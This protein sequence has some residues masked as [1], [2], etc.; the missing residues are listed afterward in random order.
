[1]K[2]LKL[3]E[4]QKFS[5]VR[6]EFIAKIFMK[7]IDKQKVMC[8]NKD[9]ER[10]VFKL[11]EYKQKEIRNLVKQGMAI[12]ITNNHSEDAIPEP[13]EVVGYSFGIYGTNAKLDKGS[14]SGKLYAVTKATSTMYRW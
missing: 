2:N 14:L 3:T 13:Y 1:M 10:E 5:V 8:Y 9:T 7:T 4:K 12:D 11:K 6:M